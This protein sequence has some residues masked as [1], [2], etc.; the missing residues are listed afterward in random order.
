MIFTGLKKQ[1]L[2]S[3]T[4]SDHSPLVT[5]EELKVMV[6]LSEEEGVIDQKERELVHSALDFND[7]VVGEILTP[8][9]DMD[10]S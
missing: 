7:I 10:C 8:R 9:I 2:K 4:S 5:E 3:F 6:T 1:F